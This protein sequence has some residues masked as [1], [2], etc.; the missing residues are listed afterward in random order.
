MRLALLTTMVVVGFFR[1]PIGLAFCCMSWRGTKNDRATV[2]P[3]LGLL[4]VLDGVSE[5]SE[6][7]QVVD[8]S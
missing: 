7:M 2:G 6:L 1:L 5:K 8:L 3:A 4:V